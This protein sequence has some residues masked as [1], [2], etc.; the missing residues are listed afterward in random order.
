M[1]CRALCKMGPV[2][3]LFGLVTLF[4]IIA[5]AFGNLNLYMDAN[6]TFRLLG[7]TAEL[8]YVR[9]GIINNYALSFNLPIPVKINTL[10]FTWQSLRIPPPEMYYSMKIT[11]DNPR[12]LRQPAANI[13]GEGKVPNTLS[14]FK[15]DFQCTGMLSTEVNVNIQMNISIFSAS[16]LTVLNFK[17][18]KM[19]LKD[20]SHLFRELSTPQ[21]N[22]FRGQN[23]SS[24]FQQETKQQL[25]NT[26][27]TSTH[28]FYIAIGCACA[29]ILLIALAVAVYYLNTQKTGSRAYAEK[30]SMP[31]GVGKCSNT[32]A[33]CDTRPTCLKCIMCACTDRCSFYALSS[34]E[35]WD[36]AESTYQSRKKGPVCSSS[37]QEDPL[38]FQEASL[39]P[40]GMLPAP[41]R[42]VSMASSGALTLPGGR[43]SSDAP[44]WEG[45][46]ALPFCRK[47]VN[48]CVDTSSS[49]ALTQQ[50]QSF[51]RADTPN[52][53][54]TSSSFRNYP[55]GISPIPQLRGSELT[56]Q[57][58]IR[59]QDVK[60]VLAEIAIERSRISLSD[61]IMEGTFGR[62]YRGTL[63]SEDSSQYGENEFGADQEI[64]VKTVTDQA[65]MDQVQ[66][67]LFES[68]MMKGLVHQNIFPIIGA[69]VDGLGQPLTIY[70][71]TS[72]GNLKKFIQQCRTSECGSH[73][74]LSTQQLVYIAIQ[75]I[76]GIQFLHRKKIIHKDISTRNCVI[77]SDLS[78]RITDNA[79][80]RDLFPGDYDCLGD[81][82][83]RPVKWL[84]VEA[85]V[86][87]RYSTASD[88]WAFGVT[89]WELMTMGQQ[90]YGD[91]DS[92]EMAAY[93][94]E[95]YRIAQPMNCPDELFAVMACCWAM[96]PDERP[97]FS[98]LLACLHDFYTALGRYI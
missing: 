86:E 26:L 41:I 66:L 16:N 60:S 90:P 17:R 19:C 50:T 70:P 33:A 9:T 36:L 43:K 82:E 45:S 31:Q 63:L 32:M 55:R 74:A 54:I 49:Q 98:Q 87:R 57:E 69:T 39:A 91:I 13:D 77:D 95:G 11:V 21:P 96:N 76:R 84:A 12:A 30:I 38:H 44:V 20:D 78:I 7:I 23:L 94:Q 48:T 52:K 47:V 15:I 73:Y 3:Q 6:E 5:S 67:F 62:I 8:Y 51:L 92:F 42:E 72:E 79:L 97:K 29:F 35:V 80:S 40:L 59:P 46:A 71:Y 18:R 56:L 22:L 88:V 68:C 14:V 83:N 1:Y 10:Y 25:S 81:N 64:V 28:V 65:R 24:N 34:D 27:G 93:L 85:I 37:S 61:V 2:Y 53:S 4:G 75:I 89:L 58:M